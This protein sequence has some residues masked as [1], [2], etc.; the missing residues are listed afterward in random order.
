MPK[1]QFANLP[2]ERQAAILLAATEEFAGSGYGRAS[3]NRIVA[4]AG[5]AKGSLFYYFSGKEDLYHSVLRRAKDIYLAEIA[6]HVGNSLPADLVERLQVL[7]TGALAVLVAHPLEYRVLMGMAE[8]GGGAA[9][10]VLAEALSN[11]DAELAAL[12][13]GVDESAFLLE[14]AQTYRLVRWIYAGIK[15]D[16]T[17]SAELRSNPEALRSR[18]LQELDLALDGLRQL[19][20]R[21]DPASH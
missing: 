15:L 7:T 6:R 8:K 14:P 5:I 2:E 13:T 12:M 20:L 19:L 21:P 11:P 3:T 10:P 18:F 4:A 9:A 1:A 16:L 17:A